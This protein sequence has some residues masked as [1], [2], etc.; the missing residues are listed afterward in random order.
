MLFPMEK[1]FERYVAASL[2]S[3]LPANARI[4]TQAASEW[5]CF[6]EEDAMFRLRPDILIELESKRWVLD[7]KWKRID[8]NDR[9]SKYQISQTDFYQMFAYGH[10]YLIGSGDMALIYPLSTNFSGSIKAF[11]FDSHLRVHVLAFD[12]EANQLIF[13]GQDNLPFLNSTRVA[14]PKC[15]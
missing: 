9:Q 2:R 13:D 5:L 7:T 11:N 4:I 14:I 8:Q 3:V 1:L 6:Q 10:R 12:L 15:G